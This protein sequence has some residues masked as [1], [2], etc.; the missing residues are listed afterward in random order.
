MTNRDIYRFHT[1][2][3]SFEAWTLDEVADEIP[4]LPVGAS[5]VSDYQ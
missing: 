2:P 1:V 3:A 4:A 5:E